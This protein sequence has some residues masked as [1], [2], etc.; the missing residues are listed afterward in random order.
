MLRRLISEWCRS[1]FRQRPAGGDVGEILDRAHRLQT[2]GDPE[3]A[4]RAL[5]EGIEQLPAQPALWNNLGL[6]YLARNELTLAE[7]HFRR[8]LALQ[9][10][11]AQAHCN[12]GIALSELGR[13]AEAVGSFQQA[14]AVA[15]GLLAARENLARLLTRQMEDV[16]A[17]AAWDEVLGLKPGHAEAHA[18][19][20]ILRMRA[21]LF[22]E[23]RVLFP[24]ARELGMNTPAIALHEAL[25]EAAVGDPLA[26]RRS[27]MSLRGQVED[28]ELDWNLAL[29]HLSCGEFAEGWR[30]YE[31]RLRRSF[32]SPRRW[33][34]F[35]PWTGGALGAGALLV[36]AEQGLGDEVMFASCYPDVLELAPRCVIE[37]DPRLA[38]L[39]ARSFPD[40]S[41]IGVPR[42]ND[43][44]WLDRYPELRCQVHAGSLAGWFRTRV[45]RF[46]RRAGYL[47]PDPQRVETWANRLSGLGGG[48]KIGIAWSGGLVHTRRAL[49]SIPL[50]QLATLLRD[51]GHAFVSLQHDDDGSE[52][53]RLAEVSGHAVHVFADALKDLDETA[54]L[55]RSLDVVL[56]VCSSLAHL[57]GAVGA[58]T[59]VLTPR[60]AEWRYLRTGDTLPWYPSVRLF[61]QAQE[62]EWTPV[63][64]E[65][66]ARLSALPAQ[67]A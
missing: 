52:A 3:A 1:A 53:G 56:T 67:G 14:I 11:L 50:Q 46:P 26:A 8:A 13:A 33:Y 51:S 41:V 22:D 16:A 19:K 24:R 17:V 60:V 35:A 10:G 47:R 6:L 5:Q 58:T 37:C 30:L 20:G 9:P 66:A 12:L 15:P 40:A 65:I 39:F 27:L 7:R 55:L 63:V 23:A 34:P 21:G 29:I 4:S 61:R 64:A 59:W 32:E 62:G 44:R 43:R 57:S 49:R 2:A 38:G 42:G 25:V 48:L 36:M 45:E 54:A 18:A 31:A 28:A